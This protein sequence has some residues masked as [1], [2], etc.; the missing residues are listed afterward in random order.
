MVRPGF[1]RTVRID[2]PRI[3]A[4][5]TWVEVCFLIVERFEGMTIPAIQF[6]GTVAKV[7]SD[8]E[9][10]KRWVLQHESV[11]LIRKNCTI[12]GSGLCPRRV[13]V[14]HYHFEADDSALAYDLDTLG[15]VQSVHH[16]RFATVCAQ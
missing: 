3:A 15:L 11:V 1:R 8:S 10:T 5:N 7:T 12:Q 9:A 2:V 16:R 14:Y 13:L 4:D 6:V